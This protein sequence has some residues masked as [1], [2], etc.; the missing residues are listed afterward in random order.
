MRIGDN[1]QDLTALEL[2]SGR[3]HARKMRRDFKSAVLSAITPSE[4]SQFVKKTRFSARMKFDA[5]DRISIST[6][7]Y[8][9]K[10]HYGFEGIKSNGVRMR[11]RSFNH[12]GNFFDRT[13]ALD[14]LATEISELR[15]EAVTAEASINIKLLS[16]G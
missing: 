12:F 5:L 1:N 7:H 2:Q 3:K 8:I 11:M 6:P 4:F 9:F 14:E 15:G 16:D 10:Q 13:T